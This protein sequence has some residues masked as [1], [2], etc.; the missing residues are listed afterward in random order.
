MGKAHDPMARVSTDPWHRQ[1]L[2]NM[3]LREEIA[4]LSG[5]VRMLEER[6]TLA[7]SRMGPAAQPQTG[8]SPEAYAEWLKRVCDQP[9]D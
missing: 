2:T 9:E 3:R 6:L 4:A 7:E 5:R 8:L 1:R